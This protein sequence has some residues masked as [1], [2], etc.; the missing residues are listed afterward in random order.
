MDSSSG[1]VVNPENKAPEIHLVL[2]CQIFSYHIIGHWKSTRALRDYQNMALDML[3]ALMLLTRK[4][5][6]YIL[7]L[8]ITN[9]VIKFY[10]QSIVV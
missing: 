9:F 2:S 8:N 6:N 10:H 7:I 4:Q 1:P 5:K 3:K